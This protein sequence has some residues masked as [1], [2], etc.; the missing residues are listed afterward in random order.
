VG[1][2]AFRLRLTRVVS[3]AKLSAAGACL[4][5]FTAGARAP[6]WVIAGAVTAT[7]ALLVLYESAK[8]PCRSELRAGR[9]G[10]RI[11]WCMRQAKVEVTLEAR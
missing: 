3:Y 11:V 5:I 7:L 4:V 2:A 9:A 8:A 1:H 6:S 10:L